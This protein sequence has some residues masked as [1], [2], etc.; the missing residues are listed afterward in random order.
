MVESLKELLIA[1]G[2]APPE[3]RIEYRD[4]IAGYGAAAIEEMSEWARDPNY[5]SFAI[6][7][8]GQAAAHGA[9]AEALAALRRIASD[10]ASA[11]SST[12]PRSSQ[13]SASLRRR[14]VSRLDWCTPSPRPVEG[15]IRVS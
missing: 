3:R 2:E 15:W 12:P 14:R 5:V 6:R 7:V 11:T 1:A 8:I 9:L 13:G 4:R 10:G